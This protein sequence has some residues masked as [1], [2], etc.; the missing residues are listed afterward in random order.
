M[1][2]IVIIA[3]FNGGKWIDKCFSSLRKSSI[4]LH[5]LAIDNASS[6]NTVPQIRNQFPEV[7]LIETGTNLGFG[8]ANNIGLKKALDENADYVFLLNQDAWIET[9]TIENLIQVAEENK[10]YGIISPFHFDY[11]GSRP[12][13][14]FKEWVMAHYTKDLES[15]WKSGKTKEIYPTSFIHAACWLMPISTIRIIGGFDPLFFHYGEDNDYVQRLHAKNMLIG[16]VPDTSLY[17]QG[18]N[19]GLKKPNENIPCL[20]NE[21]LLLFK[22]TKASTKG[23]LALFFK[24][25]LKLHLNNLKS[26]LSKAYRF[27]LR[28][29]LK[30]LKSRKLQDRPFAYL[31]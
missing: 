8:K 1:K 4:P 15:D 2:V 27:N 5:I 9:N 23:V 11:E 16:I 12:E 25:F 21:S 20:I 19:D 13:R 28:R 17:H 24:Q 3:T 29:L 26:P 30:I 22:N 7:E 31:K 10:E 18:S 14:Y 6:D